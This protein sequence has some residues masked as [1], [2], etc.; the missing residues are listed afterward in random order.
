MTES[1]MRDGA[2]LVGSVPLGDAESVFRRVGE[3]LG[4]CLARIPDGETGERTRW[5]YWQREMLERHPAMELDP[6][7]PPLRLEE[8]DGTFLRESPLLRFKP[9]IDPDSVDFETGYGR[10]ALASY[11]VFARLKRTG[12]LPACVR[13][14][15]SLP[16][17][18]SSA[19]MYVSPK[20]RA[21]YLR[22]YER[23]LLK[24]LSEILEGIPAAELALQWD[25]CQEVL[26][27][28]NYFPSRPQGY[29]A[30]IFELL[31]RLGNAVP[32]AAELGYHLCYGSPRDRHLVMPRDT[33]ILVE[34]ANGSF[35][36]LRR[37]AT[38]LH[39][40][41]PQDRTD[42]DYYAPLA[43]L[44]LPPGCRLFL[45]LIHHADEAG[46]RARIDRAQ[47]VVHDFGIAAECGWGRTEPE[48]VPGF[49]ESHAKAV[50]YLAGAP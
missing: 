4:P 31:A 22:V 43:D 34:I 10:A 46:D 15:V 7:V 44:R 41:V 48:R 9:G 8:W 23:A 35:A 39:L 50:R 36:Q 42:P 27:F 45:G 32:A 20:S 12:V 30:W 38:W 24:A 19:F 18:A 25:V 47:E 14:Q 16:T 13:F 11:A 33:A 40:P 21:D 3:V 37:P 2:L 49:L 1:S 26:I 17:P 29:K 28:E 6:E 5:V